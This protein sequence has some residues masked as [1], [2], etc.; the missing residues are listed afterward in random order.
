MER[1]APEAGYGVLVRAEHRVIMVRD[2]GT[3]HRLAAPGEE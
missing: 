3:P 1:H 2:G